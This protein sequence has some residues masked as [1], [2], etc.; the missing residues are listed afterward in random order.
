MLLSHLR[1]LWVDLDL[2]SVDITKKLN[3]KYKFTRFSFEE[4]R[5]RRK[6]QHGAEQGQ[7]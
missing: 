5:R 2:Y 4:C 6:Q 7:G 3:L 1:D